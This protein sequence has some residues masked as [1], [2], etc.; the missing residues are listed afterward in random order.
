MIVSAIVATAK[1]KV[2]GKDNDIP[3]HLPAD[4]K[5]FKAKT[6]NHLGMVYRNLGKYQR[7]LIFCHKALE[8]SK[9]YEDSVLESSI[10]NNI[11]VIYGMQKI[12]PKS[13]EYLY[14]SNTESIL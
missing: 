11:G 13:L 5:Y 9:E 6:L 8:I 14:P 3:W 1:N 4:L 7:A 12:Y 2:I 10:L